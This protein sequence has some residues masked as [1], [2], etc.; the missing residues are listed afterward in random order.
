MLAEPI[1]LGVINACHHYFIMTDKEFKK[2][3]FYGKKYFLLPSL[4]DV[5]PL[6]PSI[7]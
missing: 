2:S 4:S 7:S 6:K 1:F 3:C 5:L